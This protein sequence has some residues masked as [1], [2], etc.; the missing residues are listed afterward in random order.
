M[1]VCH[2]SN[3]TIEAVKRDKDQSQAQRHMGEIVDAEEQSEQTK[4]A[5]IDHFP[6]ASKGKKVEQIAYE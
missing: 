1:G 2:Q 6:G 5:L 3:S 4:K